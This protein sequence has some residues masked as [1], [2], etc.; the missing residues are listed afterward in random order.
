MYSSSVHY[1]DSGLNGEYWAHAL[2]GVIEA[3]ALTTPANS[4]NWMRRLWLLAGSKFLTVG[5]GGAANGV[6]VNIYNPQKALHVGG[7]VLIAGDEGGYANAVGLTNTTDTAVST[8]TGTVKMN[9]TTA[10]NSDAWVKIYIGTTAYWI[11]AWS[12]IN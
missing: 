8:G 10:R 12:N 9:S 2:D 4:G 7:T 3:P 5:T 11:P 6:G 1:V